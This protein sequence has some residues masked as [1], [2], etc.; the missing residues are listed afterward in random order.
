[1]AEAID[2]GGP[3][4]VAFGVA[5]RMLGTIADAEDVAQEA[6]LR[7]HA[8]EPVPARP[9]AWVTTVATRLAIDRLTSAR[10]RRET[11]VGPWLPEP[12]LDAPD[13]AAGDP[14][15]DVVRAETLSLA[16]LAVLERLS[17][18]ERAAFL[19]HDAFAYGYAEVAEVLGRSEA[20]CRQLVSR[21]RRAVQEDRPRFDPDPARRRAVA[22]A[23]LAAAAGEDVDGLAGVLAED[24]VLR[25]DAGGER[26]SPRRVIVGARMV[27]RVLVGIRDKGVGRE[28]ADA[29]VVRPFAVNGTPGLLFEHHG[30]P[31]SLLAVDVAG[32]RVR[33]VHL[34]RNPGKLAAALRRAEAGR[35]VR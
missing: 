2:L 1:M 3:R 21:A 7:L 15:D 16:L 13:A 5:Y 8:A 30:T 10:A 17:P 33:A 22:E 34:L 26:P 27:A 29:W 32:D 11:Y 12:L 4:A 28:G 18:V 25:A 9:D 6:V 19:L 23:F 14:A 35:W 20:A 24:C 31:D